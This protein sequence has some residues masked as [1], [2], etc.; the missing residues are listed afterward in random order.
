MRI[1]CD[2]DK[3][4]AELKEFHAQAVRKMTGM[5]ILF[6]YNVTISASQNTPVG[7]LEALV[8][9]ES[10]RNFY[11]K[12][13]QEYG[14]EINVGFHAGAWHYSEEWALGFDKN[15]YAEEEAAGRVQQDM[16]QRF[17][18]GDYFFIGAKGP[19]FGALE[20]GYSPKAPD[21]IMKPT[22]QDI[23]NIYSLNLAQYYKEIR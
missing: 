6:A 8:Q 21:G 16:K 7:D 1:V 10:Y 4:L 23:T 11:L 2:T 20:D 17:M 9:R 19:G 13:F 14:I 15:I 5:V 12:R 18:L 3:V 22:M